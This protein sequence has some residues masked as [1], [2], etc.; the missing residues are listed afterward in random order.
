MPGSRTEI[1]TVEQIIKSMSGEDDD[2]DIKIP[3]FQRGV[4]W[5]TSSRTKLVDSILRGYPI[6]SI[7]LW[8]MPD[9][10]GNKVQYALIDGLQRS[11]S[12]KK[13]EDNPELHLQGDWLSS[14]DWFTEFK[15]EFAEVESFEEDFV[16]WLRE[17]NNFSTLTTAKMTRFLTNLIDT[18]Y[19]LERMES[20][21]EF[22]GDMKSNFSLLSYT[23]PVVIYDGPKAELGEIFTRI[24]KEGRPLS[25]L[26][27]IAAS[28]IESF[29]QLDLDKEINAEIADKC[30]QRLILFEEDDY[31]IIGFDEED[32][33][34]YC[35]DLF[36]YL[37]GLG[38]VLISTGSTILKET[39]HKDPDT[40][41]FYMLGICNKLP[42]S[43]LDELPTVL[44][45]NPDLSGFAMAA[46]DS[47]ETVSTWFRWL[48][49]LNLNS[50]RN[51]SNFYPHS[52]NQIISI[53]TRVLLEKY[54]LETWEV[55]GD[56]EYRKENLKKTIKIKYL[57]DI[58]GGY[59][60]GSGDNKMF[61]SCWTATEL[62]GQEEVDYSLSTDYTRDY[63]LEVTGV[64]LDAWFNSQMNG[65]QKKRASP[66]SDQKLA[67]KYIYSP[68]VTVQDN[69][70]VT[71][72]IEH[73]NSVSHMKD[74]IEHEGSEGWAMNSI[75]NL[76]LLKKEINRAK[77]NDSVK[78]YL[79]KE[80]VEENHKE[81]IE[82][83]L[84][85][86][87]ENIP[88]QNQLT[89]QTYIQYC[90]RRWP[91]VR[92][93]ILNSLGYE[94]VDEP[95]ERADVP[96][97]GEDLPTEIF[98]DGG[99]EEG[100]VILGDN[101]EISPERDSLTTTETQ[102][103]IGYDISTESSENTISDVFQNGENLVIAQESFT[104][105]VIGPQREAISEYDDYLSEMSNIEFTDKHAPQ[106]TSKIPEDVV[107]ECSKK[108]SRHFRKSISKAEKRG[109]SK[110]SSEDNSLHITIHASKKMARDKYFFGIQDQ[111]L[112]W[113]SSRSNG[114]NYVA[115]VCGSTDLTFLIPLEIMGTILTKLSSRVIRDGRLEYWYVN[116]QKTEDGW[117]IPSLEGYENTNIQSYLLP[118]EA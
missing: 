116:V 99:A 111:Q 107:I 95:A 91:T 69:A 115:L 113:H 82:E 105:E 117:E 23:V 24:N 103:P 75:S 30:K 104:P 44:G 6:G 15:L 29:V 112:N 8:R 89:E 17:E 45:A 14:K 73:I 72:E 59:W 41:A 96:A 77:G 38:K 108:L 97:Q 60:Q 46:K 65:K 9:M 118:S 62:E 2:R 74:K 7:L 16:P 109:T 32:P 26:Q 81:H 67:M 31:E 66:K 55:R 88:S 13:Y 87:V 58:L 106:G 34:S 19:V 25:S 57:I 114:E 5:S 4:V 92:N 39:N 22:V 93:S 35:R 47:V 37:F 80:D 28:W 33:D 53:V 94:V 12:L 50:Q 102:Q 90:Q 27:I 1:F 52:L 110:Y 63:S 98:A 51:D 70:D 64:I 18:D 11:T 86:S 10:V 84:L 3:H 20:V 42:V 54:N 68:L 49:D 61:S 40:I 101:E 85:D 36:Q 48:T 43:K 56:W 71:F 21:E 79:S 78:E 100:N 76:M 83:Y